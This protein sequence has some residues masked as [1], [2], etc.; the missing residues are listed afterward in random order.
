MTAGH[1]GAGLRPAPTG[2]RKMLEYM[3]KSPVR[4]R[5]IARAEDYPCGSVR[6]VVRARSS[7]QAEKRR[8]LHSE[9]LPESGARERGRGS[10]PSRLP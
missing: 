1:R 9:R 5:I 7:D 6:P 2:I 3:L 8:R 4:K 10:M